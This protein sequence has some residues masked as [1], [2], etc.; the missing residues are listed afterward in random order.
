M[1]LLIAGVKG[2][3]GQ[4]LWALAQADRAAFSAVD[5]FDKGDD[6][7]ERIRQCD[8]V[9]D[10]TAPEATVA[11]LPRLIS[12]GKPCVIGATG[13]TAEQDEAVRR[14]AERIA[15]VKSANMS[16]GVNL[17]FKLAQSAARTLPGYSAKIQETHHVHKKD[18]PSGTALQTGRL[19]EEA[20]GAKPAYESFREGEV[21]GDHRV[22]LEGP[23]DRLELFHHAAS[24]DIFAAGALQAARWLA[25]KRPGLYSMFDVLGL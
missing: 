24:R 17:F 8:V 25:G 10:F 23:M 7:A 6:P 15:I 12:A 21:V 1:K 3:M 9:V 20:G 5:G 19:M 16:P 11:L 18:A 14:A 4:R 2:R 13:F 22:I